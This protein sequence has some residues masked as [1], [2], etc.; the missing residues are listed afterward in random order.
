MAPQDDLTAEQ[1]AVQL[2]DLIDPWVPRYACK[3]AEQSR[4][5]KLALIENTIKEAVRD[6]LDEVN[7]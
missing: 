3:Q 7:T 5:I 2:L 1:R 4:K 6:A